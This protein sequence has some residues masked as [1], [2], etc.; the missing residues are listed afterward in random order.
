[1]NFQ[2]PGNRTLRTSTVTDQ[3]KAGVDFFLQVKS[4]GAKGEVNTNRQGK[5]ECFHC[6][7]KDNLE[8]LVP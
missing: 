8:K 2:T 6:G 5:Y 1:M 7:K 3:E 4:P